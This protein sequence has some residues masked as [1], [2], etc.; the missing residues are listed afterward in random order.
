MGFTIH[1][2][3]Q[4]S[5]EW[6]KARCGRLTASAAKD[7]LSEVKSG[8]SAKRR[9]LRM[10]LVVER[11]T[12][13]WEVDGFKSVDMQRGVEL[14]PD[15]L[16]GYEAL[17]GNLVSSVGFLSH[18]E[19]MAG[20]S[21]DGVIGDFAGLVELKCP[22]SATHWGYLRS[23]GLPAEHVA[24]LTHLLWLTD[25]PWIDFLSFDPRFPKKMQ[26]FLMRLNRDE[27]Q[28]AAYD[29]KVRAFL[30]EVDI[31]VVAAQGWDILREAV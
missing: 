14:E 27:A 7:M 16:K 12:G 30:K 18:N 2:V 22:K 19:L 25:V 10:R 26:T 31:E 11:L 29:A 24:Q 17:T 5:G 4:R 6:F 9:D 20:G 28:I 13:E 1:D 8:E 15:A 23:S 3:P 21:P